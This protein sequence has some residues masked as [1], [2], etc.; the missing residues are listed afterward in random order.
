MSG[1]HFDTA[2]Y[3]IAQ[4]ADD[5]E[6]EVN[7]PEDE[8]GMQIDEATAIAIKKFVIHLN[9]VAQAIQAID[10]LYSGDSGED[11]V[12]ETITDVL[13]EKPIPPTYCWDNTLNNL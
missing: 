9:K 13:N 8:R 5:I 3:R 2:Y 12:I 10:Y 11:R 6:W 4:L 1:G 7:H